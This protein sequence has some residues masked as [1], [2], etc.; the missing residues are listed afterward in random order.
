[1]LVG[2]SVA[3][4]S[5]GRVSPS[6]LVST[7]ASWSWVVL[8]QLAIAAVMTR[9]LPPRGHLSAARAFDLWFAAHV[10]WTAWLL[11]LGP[12]LRLVPD[13]DVEVII[14]SMLAPMAWTAWITV[15]FSRVVLEQSPVVAALRAA[16]HQAVLL[17]IILSYVAWSAG[18]W[19]RIIG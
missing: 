13:L 4:A 16:L 3:I 7:L 11:V 10:P 14:V 9:P 19:F 1:M 2:T 5:A 18:G 6:L 12:V 8:V 17:F 15:A